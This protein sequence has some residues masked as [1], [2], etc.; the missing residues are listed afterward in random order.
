MDEIEQEKEEEEEEKAR[1]SGILIL[2]IA[3]KTNLL[4]AVILIRR[5]QRK[6][7][8]RAPWAPPLIKIMSN[9]KSIIE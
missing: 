4:L 2:S 8:C 7:C 6:W 1:I 3:L 5:F 9:P